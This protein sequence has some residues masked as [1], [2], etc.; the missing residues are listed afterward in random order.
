M[1]A[2]RPQLVASVGLIAFLAASVASAS[3]TTLL[4]LQ[5]AFGG[6]ASSSSGPAPSAEEEGRAANDL[7]AARER[8][9]AL[10]MPF[11]EQFARWHVY[12]RIL[13]TGA[14]ALTF[15]TDILDQP[16]VDAWRAVLPLAAHVVDGR[17]P[18]SLLYEIYS[19]HGIGTEIV[20]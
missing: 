12:W 2:V 18:H 16:L 7:E 4:R 17:M 13:W 5:A 8:H 11:I 19:D 1:N 14:N 3:E 20:L 15:Q 9:K 10:W 6:G